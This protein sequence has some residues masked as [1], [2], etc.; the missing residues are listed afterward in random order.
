MFRCMYVNPPKKGECD[1]DVDPEGLTRQEFKEECD[2]NR[3]MAR[4]GGEVP[5]PVAGDPLYGDFSE[6]GDYQAA[7]DVLLR[8]REQFELLPSKVRDRFRNDPEAFLAFVGD[9]ENAD[10]ARKLGLLKPVEPPPPPAVPM[11]VVIVDGAKF[12]PEVLK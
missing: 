2:I 11:E 3:I 8:A 5:L 10:E 9:Q 7:R 1:T 4:Y 12:K 6:L